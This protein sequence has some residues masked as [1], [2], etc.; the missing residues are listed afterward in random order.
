MKNTGRIKKTSFLKI[1]VIFFVLIICLRV[2][3]YFGSS[4]S[5]PE[6]PEYEMADIKEEININEVYQGKMD[7]K[8]QEFLFYQTGLGKEGI[9]TLCEECES[10]AELLNRLKFYQEQLF[11]GTEE[12]QMVSLKN[13]D[14]L[15]SLSQRFFYYHHGHAAIVID[16]VENTILEA[17]SYRAGSCVGTTKKWSTISSFVVLRL[18]E[19]VIREYEEKEHINPAESAAVYAAQNLD[20]L[21][22]SLLKALRPL[23]DTTPEYTQCAHLVWYAYYACGL[24]I[25]ENRGFIIK[26]RDFLKSDV[27]EVV[28]VYGM[29]PKELLEIQNE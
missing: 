10:S 25:D 23:S 5:P 17:K 27:F 19:E 3:D 13:G 7:E 6:Y 2:V 16:G 22:Y 26:P 4:D 18:K 14:V 12:T 21:K 24:D 29:S 15:V 28:Q 9:E 1:L 20:G 11:F 8:T